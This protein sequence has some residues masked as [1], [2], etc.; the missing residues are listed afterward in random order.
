MVFKH[1][2]SRRNI[3][4]GSLEKEHGHGRADDT[5]EQSIS[6]YNLLL[7]QILI[8]TSLRKID[9]SLIKVKSRQD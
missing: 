3:A 1:R 2:K 5:S 6:K 4:L 9:Q 8:A 7:D